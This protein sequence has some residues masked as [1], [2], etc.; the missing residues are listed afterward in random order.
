MYGGEGEHA[1]TGLHMMMSLAFNVVQGIAYL[2]AADTR[3]TRVPSVSHRSW[4][5]GATPELALERECERDRAEDAF[6]SDSASASSSPSASASDPSDSKRDCKRGWE[7]EST[8]GLT[9]ASGFAMVE[10]RE[11]GFRGCGCERFE[12]CEVEWEGACR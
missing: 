3:Q 6:A 1:G 7:L 11:R 12:S 4:L 10:A 2:L 8:R 9:L 5:P